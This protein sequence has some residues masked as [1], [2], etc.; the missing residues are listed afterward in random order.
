MPSARKLIYTSNQTINCLALGKRGSDTV[1]YFQSGD[2]RIGAVLTNATEQ[3]DSSVLPVTVTNEA[4]TCHYMTM[5]RQWLVWSNRNG[6][7]LKYNVAAGNSTSSPMNIGAHGK[8]SQGVATVS[9]PNLLLYVSND[10]S[11][12]SQTLETTLPSN[13]SSGSAGDVNDIVWT[14]LGSFNETRQIITM[15]TA[16]LFS[17][18][19]GISFVFAPFQVGKQAQFIYRQIVTSLPGIRGIVTDASSTLSY[20]LYL[21]LLTIGALVL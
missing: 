19:S 21:I 15:N 14:L 10:T 1:L 11:I 16:V 12:R 2:F 13:P 5:S 20:S 9:S 6:V 7:I 17:T 18:S 3:T 8:A 4:L